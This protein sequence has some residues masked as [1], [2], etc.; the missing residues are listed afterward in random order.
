[1]SKKLPS[2]PDIPINSENKAILDPIKITIETREGLRGT[3]QQRAITGQDL[4]DLGL[5]TKAD[6]EQML[7]ER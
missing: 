7:R 5:A 6:L 3:V 2:I 1:M 4:I